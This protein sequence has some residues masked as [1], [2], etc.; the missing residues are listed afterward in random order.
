MAPHPTTRTGITNHGDSYGDPEFES[1]WAL[2]VALE[3][4]CAELTDSARDRITIMEAFD[5]FS[6]HG[7]HYPQ[8]LLET[9]VENLSTALA[10]LD[11]LL[12][13]LITTSTSLPD[14]LRYTRTRDL[15]ATLHTDTDPDTVAHASRS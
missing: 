3:E 5:T 2:L 10:H 15:L 4:N 7:L 9:P 1:A 8:L 13:Q 11:E 14:T 6:D 12:D